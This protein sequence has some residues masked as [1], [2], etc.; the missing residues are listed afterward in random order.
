MYVVNSN[1]SKTTYL[2]QN[3]IIEQILAFFNGWEAP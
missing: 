3:H 1:I 2:T